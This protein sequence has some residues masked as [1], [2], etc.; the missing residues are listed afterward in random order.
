MSEPLRRVGRYE[1][2]EVI[3]RGGAAVVYLARQPDL[4]RYVALK[5]LSPHHAG[6]PSFAQ[7]FVEESRVAGAMSHPSIVTVHEFFEHDGLPYIAMEYMRNGSLR[8]YLPDLTLPQLAGV[9]ESVLSGLSHGESHGIIHRDLKPENLLVA[10]DGKVKIADFGVARALGNA[11]VRSFATITGTTIGTPAYMAPEQALGESLSPATDLYSLGIIA[12]EALAGHVPFESRDTPMAVLYRHVNDPVPPIDT[13][14]PEVGEGLTDWLARML[15]KRPEDRFQSGDAAW[16]ELEDVVIALAGARWRREARIAGDA[17]A[18]PGGYMTPPG[19]TPVGRPPTPVTPTIT[20]PPAPAAAPESARP[21]EP[22]EARPAATPSPVPVFA[23]S[24]GDT[25]IRAS[26]RHV[27]QDAPAGEAAVKRRSR[28]PLILAVT[29]V[30]IGALI[31]VAVGVISADHTTTTQT[32]TTPAAR[33]AASVRPIIRTVDQTQRPDVSQIHSAI[34]SRAQ[35]NA[36]AAV[37]RAYGRATR[38]VRRLPHAQASL[39]AARS[40]RTA[41]TRVGSAWHAIAVAARSNS[42]GK[43]RSA[44]KSLLRRERLLEKAVLTTYRGG[45][46]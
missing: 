5:E 10:G 26:R 16:D 9:L 28:T 25:V 35:A 1:L 3:G 18:A 12:W 30:V 31:G 36:A 41:L 27:A 6:D 2:L 29:V 17:Q 32:I 20:D 8:P 43:Y 44:L 15:A 23:G 14:R 33:L 38:A 40:L 46:S 19:S 7:R 13:I 42:A 22:S 24:R 21:P 37:S 45:Q 39:P 11:N 4:D 34:D